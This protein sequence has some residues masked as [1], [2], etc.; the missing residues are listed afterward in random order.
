M[1]YNYEEKKRKQ[2]SSMKSIMDY[3][4]GVLFLIL[5]LVFLFHNQLNFDFSK[6]SN[7]PWLDVLFGVICIV[8]GGWRIYRGYKKNYFK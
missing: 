2:I 8:Y 6:Y 3:G 7:T 4:M 5:G 1:A